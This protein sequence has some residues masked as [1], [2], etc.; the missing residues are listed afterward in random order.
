MAYVSKSQVIGFIKEDS[1]GVLKELTA[2]SDFVKLREGGSISGA[3]ESINSDELVAGSIGASKSYV[4]KEV[5]T[6]SFPKYLKHSGTQGVA[7]Q[8]GLLIESCLGAVDV[9]STE[10]SVTTGSSAG[11]ASARA[12][13]EMATNQEDN[14]RVGQAVL[15]KDA[16]NNYSI[17]NIF[18][19]DSTG[20]QLD[21]NFNLAAA[22]AS[23]IGL[24]KCVG[25]YPSTNN[26]TF[27][28]HH[29]QALVGS[30]YKQAMAG[31]RTTSMSLTFPANN[32][33]ESSYEFAGINFYF[34]PIRI[35]STNKHIDFTDDAGTVAAV[36]TEKV[37]KSPIAFA[38]E[39]ASKMTAASVGSGNDTITCTY[40]N[41]TGKYTLASNGT[42]FSL[43]WSSG[44]NTLTSAG[45]TLGFSVAA[46]DTAATSYVG[47]S[48]I[49][50]DTGLTP[51]YETSDNLIIKN[52]ELFIGDFADNIC[53]KASTASINIS[54]PKTDVSSI[55]AESGVVESVILSREVT[56]S[57]TILLEKFQ[58]KYVDNLLNNN[59]VS[60][61]FNAGTKTA[62]NW[63]AG[64]CVNVYLPSCS[65][66]AAPVADQDGYQV[67]NLEATA[68]VSGALDDVYI[69][70]L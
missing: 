50:F 67:F 18:N 66:T 21:L 33:A 16:T 24:G 64:K 51:S 39:V 69:N 26:P 10:Y 62:G 23:G 41:V 2:G 3:V 46:D 11:T 48:A 42:T 57:A 68:F 7:P 54:T 37:Y 27:S 13:L 28:V 6:G 4:V 43:L 58:S 19:I 56:F 45:T 15:I 22:P 52:N 31:C 12:A 9:E 8:G 47:D 1:E 36:L 49:S 59:T 17:R 30:A 5:P 55:C 63:D 61:M 53:V 35:A 38:Q 34:N 60:I 65:I 40:S 29:W 32:F 20:N 25:Y 14:F 70:F 44:T